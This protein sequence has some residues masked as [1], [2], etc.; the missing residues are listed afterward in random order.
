MVAV[1][2]L[3]GAIVIGRRGRAT[4]TQPAAGRG[5][6]KMFG[7][8]YWLVVVAEVVLLFGGIAVLRAWD[9]PEQTNVAWIAVVV[10]VHFIVLAPIWKQISILVPGVILT[11]LG[12]AGLVMAETSAVA[13]VP[14]VSGVL[15]GVTLLVACVT[16]AWFGM[17]RAAQ[18][19]VAH[20]A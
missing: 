11:L 4:Q 9:L 18:G 6:R 19:Q 12:V 17:S 8:G 10:G 1:L 7:R 14:I 15:S 13:W 3:C 16:S 2:G 20:Q 5:T